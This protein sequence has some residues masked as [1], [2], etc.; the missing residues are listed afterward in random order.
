MK[1]PCRHTF[2]H[3][4]FHFK[5]A[6]FLLK[7][8]LSE[9]TQRGR[10]KKK[11]KQDYYSNFLYKKMGWEYKTHVSRILM[12]KYHFIVFS[13]I[14]DLSRQDIFNFFVL[15]VGFFIPFLF[16]FIWVFLEIPTQSRCVHPFLKA[17]LYFCCYYSVSLSNISFCT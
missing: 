7:T 10:S 12:H 8:F 1:I 16:F 11:N 15:V 13:I 4:R 9:K 6:I 5:R 2:T 14:F 3:V 17:L